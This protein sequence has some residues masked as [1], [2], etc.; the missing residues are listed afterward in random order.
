[1]DI[2]RSQIFLSYI[3]GHFLISMRYLGSASILNCKHQSI[4]PKSLNWCGKAFQVARQSS[5]KSLIRRAGKAGSSVVDFHCYNTGEEYD[6][7]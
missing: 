1:M 3:V 7:R 4:H 5:F 2:S 6:K